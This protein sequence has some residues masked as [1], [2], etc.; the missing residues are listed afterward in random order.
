MQRIEDYKTRIAQLIPPHDEAK[1][2]AAELELAQKMHKLFNLK[3]HEYDLKVQEEKERCIKEMDEENK[4]DDDEVLNLVINIGKVAVVGAVAFFAPP[5]LP[6]ALPFIGAVGTMSNAIATGVA[7]GLADAAAQGVAIEAGV[8]NSFS[9]N[10]ML[11]TTVSFGVGAG[12]GGLN[13][14]PHTLTVGAMAAGTQIVEMGIGTREEFDAQAVG[15]QAAAAVV[16]SG[17]RKALPAIEKTFGAKD[18]AMISTTAANAAVNS[19]LSSAVKGAPLDLKMMSTNVVGS[20]IG[21]KIGSNLAISF[22]PD[23]EIEKVPV[24]EAK[25]EIP[26]SR[27]GVGFFA[28]Q[29]LNKNLNLDVSNLIKQGKWDAAK[30]LAIDQEKTKSAQSNEPAK[31]EETEEI[32]TVKAVSST[33]A[34]MERMQAR[35]KNVQQATEQIVRNEDPASLIESFN[36][37]FKQYATEDWES[38][39]THPIESTANAVKETIVGAAKAVISPG[40]IGAELYD[41]GNRFF[42]SSPA[43]QGKMLARGA[44]DL[45]ETAPLALVGGEVANVARTVRLGKDVALVGGMESLVPKNP[46]SRSLD[47]IAARK[48]YHE[49]LAQIPSKLDKTLPQKEQAIQAFKLRND[50]KLQARELMSDEKLAATL[51][52]PK[53]LKDVVRNGYK[54]NYVGDQLWE[55]TLK[56][57]QKTNL[58]VDQALGIDN[59]FAPQRKRP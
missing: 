42:K 4:K 38:F 57:S 50:V 8:Q 20:I 25:L 26:S 30:A 43:T 16:A 27:Y 31:R 24:P 29:P 12:T 3:M 13:L 22:N 1:T 55:Y 28:D 7:C 44:V 54:N 40:E 23:L 59:N 39:K 56:G 18:G 33:K 32:K 11:E 5:L 17:I 2:K 35:E 45:V 36:K 48:W 15:L 49:Q 37:N 53:T 21:Q 34:L 10:E 46:L 51:D 19:I 9:V 58:I 6:G 47:N 41:L 52:P 14:I